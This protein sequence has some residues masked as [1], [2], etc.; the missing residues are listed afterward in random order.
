MSPISAASGSP[1]PAAGSPA[2][3]GFSN[4]RS[5]PWAA[6]ESAARCAGV[7]TGSGSQSART[8]AR[9]EA[10]AL[11]EICWEMIASTSAKK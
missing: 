1:A 4:R 10:A 9:I 11:I 6:R 3:A 8:R 5:G 2:N 7:R